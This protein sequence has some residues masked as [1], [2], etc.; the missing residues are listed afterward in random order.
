[1]AGKEDTNPMVR[2]YTV[3]EV[4]GLERSQPGRHQLVNAEY[5]GYLA[6]FEPGTW[7]EA[8]LVDGEDK[9]TVRRRLKA[10]GKRRGWNIKFH[11][12]RDNTVMFKIVGTEQ[13][14][15]FLQE[16]EVAA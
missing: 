8:E 1:M 15:M 16:V 5:D 4:V 9:A 12:T 10:A 3:E 7:G 6:A 13:A 2:K 11:R 14:C